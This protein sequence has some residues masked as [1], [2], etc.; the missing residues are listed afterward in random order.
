MLPGVDNR[1]AKIKKGDRGRLKAIGFPNFGT[2]IDFLVGPAGLTKSNNVK[3]LGSL[4][5]PRILDAARCLSQAIVSTRA[6][7][8]P[9]KGAVYVGRLRL[10]KFAQLKQRK[11]RAFDADDRL[12]GNFRNRARAL[13][14]I[15]KAAKAESCAR[16]KR[17]SGLGK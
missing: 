12:L 17:L 10:G 5:T 7:F 2:V 14:A 15:R 3:Y 1:A 16:A 11:F 9:I 4:E 8:K 13:K 6:A